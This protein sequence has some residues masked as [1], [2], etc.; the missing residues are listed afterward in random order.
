MA[1]VKLW[2]EELSWDLQR[3]H[4]KHCTFGI[5]YAHAHLK[6]LH[7]W[8]L[9]KLSLMCKNAPAQIFLTPGRPFLQCIKT[10]LPKRPHKG[11]DS[12]QY[13]SWAVFILSPIIQSKYQKCDLNVRENY[14][15]R[16]KERGWLQNDKL[17]Q[18]HIQFSFI[19][20]KQAVSP[21]LSSIPLC[22]DLMTERGREM[23][24]KWGRERKPELLQ[25]VG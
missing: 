24:R 19:G 13:T 12:S 8:W 15:W 25:T 14:H 22:K 3:L 18:K 21:S 20:I 17:F 2:T 9:A 11:T 10:K 23:K 4:L 6:C 5:P 7:W 16:T 1:E